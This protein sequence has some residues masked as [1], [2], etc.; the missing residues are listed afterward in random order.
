MKPKVTMY[1]IADEVGMSVAA[2]SRAF[3]PASC[4][5]PDKRALILE[6][7]ERLG[8]VPNRMAARLSSE[9]IRIGALIWGSLRVYY[10]HIEEGLREAF[11]LYKDYKVDLD[12]RILDRSEASD[13]DAAE[14]LDGFAASGCAGVIVSGVLGP[15]GT[16]ALARLSAAGIPAGLVGG[17]I[18]GTG[19]RYVSMN[20]TAVTGRI[21]AEFLSLTVRSG[22]SVI[23][24]IDSRAASGQNEIVES[25][26]TA[27][28]AYGLTVADVIST[29]NRE[30]AAFAAMNGLLG[31]GPL[32]GGFYCTSANS[33]P[34]CRAIRDRGLAGRFAFLASDVFP[35]MDPF[36]D[37]GIVTATI[38]QDPQY[39]ARAAFEAMFGLLTD[40]AV[41]SEFIRATPQLVLRSNRELYR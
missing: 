32:P 23:L 36:F 39:Q 11:R 10:G 3:D 27:A 21:A 4:L 6:T 41:P 37:D 12:L 9:P 5:K 38:F 1:T 33:V 22:R 8:Y 7:A 40:G 35:A 18:P 19:R 25:F 28:P 16:K 20:D 15:A 17:D 26:L 13:E 34:L 31:G 30:D 2:V 24:F 29:E 14:T